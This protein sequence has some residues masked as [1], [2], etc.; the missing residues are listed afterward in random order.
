MMR[1][2]GWRREPARVPRSEGLADLG[3]APELR[4]VQPWLHTREGVPLSL[5]SLSGRVVLLEFWT[6]ACGNCTR[7]LPFMR[8]MHQSYRPGLVVVGIHTPELPF[9]RRAAAVAR[10]ADEHGLTY[11]IGMDNDLAT[12]RAY[13]NSYWPSLYLIDA[14]GH[15]RYRHVGEGR[16][17]QTETAIRELLAQASALQPGAPNSLGHAA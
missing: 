17:A 12:W 11:A 13:G 14:A 1:L 10:A 16:Y 9:E 15:L 8:R 7:T 2:Q 4:G 3:L 6:F 5:A